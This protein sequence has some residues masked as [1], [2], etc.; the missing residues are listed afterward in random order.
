MIITGIAPTPDALHDRSFLPSAELVYLATR[1]LKEAH[2]THV[3][4]SLA[5]GWEQ[6]LAKA[7]LELRIPFSTSLPYA[8]RDLAWLPAARTAYRELLA[9][10]AQVIQLTDG[11]SP[12][13]VSAGDQWRIAHSNRVLALWNYDFD[14]PTFEAIRFALSQDKPVLNLWEDWRHLYSLRRQTPSAY[15]TSRRGAQ[16]FERRPLL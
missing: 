4:T 7:A 13:C 1:A 12:T 15:A 2:A 14:G 11:F 5:L 3:I 16:V 8:D 9:H 10:S 6:A